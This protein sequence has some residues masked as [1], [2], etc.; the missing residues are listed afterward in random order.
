V[1]DVILVAEEELQCMVARLQVYFGLGL[2]GAKV[3]VIEIVG[4]GFVQRR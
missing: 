3:Q 1:R 2:A 4:D